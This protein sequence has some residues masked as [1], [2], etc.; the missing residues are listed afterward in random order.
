MSQND[1]FG[2]HECLDRT[3]LIM[4]L[5]GTALCEHY[6]MKPDELKLA[7]IAHTALFNLYQLLGERTLDDSPPK[8]RAD[9]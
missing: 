5:V 9:D 4:D 8:D 2:R 7:E 6:A 3:S 1:E